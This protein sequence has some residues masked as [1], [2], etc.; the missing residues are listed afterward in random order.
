VLGFGARAAGNGQTNQFIIQLPPKAE[1][2]EAW[3]ATHN[4]MKQLP[5]SED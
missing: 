2:S 3:N 4:P 1:S 5:S